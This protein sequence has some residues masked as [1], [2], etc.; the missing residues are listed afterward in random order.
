M[1]NEASMLSILKL[2]NIV[3]AVSEILVEKGICTAEELENKINEVGEKSGNSAII[4]RLEIINNITMIIEKGKPYSEEDKKYIEENA[5]DI[6][7][8][9]IYQDI[10]KE[11]NSEEEPKTANE[12]E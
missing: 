10:L 6:Y 3:K 2:F 7:P 5:K 1:E 4:A 12:E 11:I 8:D 9:E